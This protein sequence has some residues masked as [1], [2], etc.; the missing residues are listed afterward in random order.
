M[1][2]IN[3]VPPG[4]D[5]VSQRVHRGGVLGALIHLKPNIIQRSTGIVAYVALDD[6][7]IN[8]IIVV[9]IMDL[10]RGPTQGLGKFLNRF[11]DRFHQDQYTPLARIDQHKSAGLMSR[12]AGQCAKTADSRTGTTSC[13]DPSIASSSI[14]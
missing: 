3:P 6:F 7:S 13:F 1:I 9:M 8:E 4:T 2:R 12:R 5:S 11:L 14:L 10:K